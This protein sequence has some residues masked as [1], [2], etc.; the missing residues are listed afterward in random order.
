MAKKEKGSGTR[1]T[2]TARE[3]TQQ[4]SD[5]KPTSRTAPAKKP[6]SAAPSEPAMSCESFVNAHGR[7]PA[8][9]RYLLRHYGSAAKTTTEWQK[10]VDGLKTREVS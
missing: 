1:R 2:S 7:S 10:I 8:L 3:R 6:V 4:M 5:P 9:K